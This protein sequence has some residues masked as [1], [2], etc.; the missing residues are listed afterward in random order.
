MPGWEH[1]LSKH[2]FRI[3]APKGAPV[4][5]VLSDLYHDAAATVLAAEAGPVRVPSGPKAST[6]GRRVV[7]IVMVPF[8]RRKIIEVRWGLPGVVK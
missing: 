4:P 8:F 3:S 2:Q 7:D 5:H 1:A 6:S